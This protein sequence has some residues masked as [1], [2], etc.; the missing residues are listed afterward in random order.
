[1]RDHPGIKIQALSPFLLG[2]DMTIVLLSGYKKSG[3]DIAANLL[4][5]ERGFKRAAFA[6]SLKNDVSLMFGLSK[7]DTNLQTLKESPILDRPVQYHDLFSK[8]V[9]E[10][11]F[12]EF[13]T[14]QGESPTYFNWID[15]RMISVESDGQSV[16]A[17][18]LYWTPRAVCILLGSTGRSFDPNHWVDRA[19]TY[20]GVQTTLHTVKSNI[21]V[22]DFRYRS[23]YDRVVR[24]F[25]KEN[26]KTVRIDRFSTVDS[27]DPSERDLDDFTFDIRVPNK[28][29]LQE[30]MSKIKEVI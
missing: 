6:D 25:G 22:S 5:Q 3:K 26:V 7:N 10:F 23:E 24:L 9:N 19:L 20:P 2:D 1:M 21:V 14:E 17:H 18:Q 11:L 27:N 30:F 13:R 15:H 8:M 28:G 16:E 4:V 12:K 29:T